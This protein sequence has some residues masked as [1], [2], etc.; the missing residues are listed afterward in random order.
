MRRINTR[1]I[2]VALL[3]LASI[4]SYAYLSSMSSQVEASSL[5]V[6]ATE[7]ESTDQAELLMP[8]VHMVKK[9]LEL[10]KRIVEITQ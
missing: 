4:C 5:E 6:E 7:A 9:V 2:L 3:A 8:D 10:G 1:T